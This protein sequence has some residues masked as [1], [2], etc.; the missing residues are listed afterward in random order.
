MDERNRSLAGSAPLDPDKAIS[1][2]KG[3]AGALRLPLRRVHTSAFKLPFTRLA[4]ADHS[5]IEGSVT[6]GNASPQP[7]RIVARKDG[8]WLESTVQQRAGTYP[9]TL[10]FHGREMDSRLHVTVGTRGQLTFS[11]QDPQP[12]PQP[13]NQGSRGYLKSARA[14]IWS[15]SSRSVRVVILML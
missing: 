14:M 1:S 6:V 8:V 12:K 11:R 10:N 7:A 13:D 9:M 4:T 2:R 5:E 3:I 15:A